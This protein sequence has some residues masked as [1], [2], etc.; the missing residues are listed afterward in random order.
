MV[1]RAA[2][3]PGERVLD[4][5]TGTGNAAAAAVGMGRRVVGVDAATGML[6]IARARVPDAEFVQADFGLLPFGDGA[7][8]VVIAVHAIN[9]A[10]DPSAVL[11]EWRRVATD[12]ARLSLSFPGPRECLPVALYGDVWTRY[13]LRLHDGTPVDAVI[14][15]AKTAGWHLTSTD[16]DPTVEIVL[17]DADAF[18]RWRS[19]GSRGRATAGWPPERLAALDADMLAVTP[20]GPDGTLRIPFG[21]LFVTATA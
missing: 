19:T 16:A 10:D 7:F 14:T 5:G 3:R 11:L 4:V 1:V 12:G 13:G 15:A 17:A 18:H 2:L 20:R 8:D 21:A 6:E 9:F